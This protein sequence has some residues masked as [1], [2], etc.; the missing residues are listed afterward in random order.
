[1]N[2]LTEPLAPKL[3]I[4][5]RPRHSRNN[6]FLGSRFAW[7]IKK[8]IMSTIHSVLIFASQDTAMELRD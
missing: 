1:M 4:S 7:N 3:E 5:N 2:P 8:Q 6:V